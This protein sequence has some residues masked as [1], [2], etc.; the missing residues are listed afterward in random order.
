MKIG[1]EYGEFVIKLNDFRSIY[2]FFFWS[3]K[4]LDGQNIFVI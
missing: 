1:Y 3:N 4:P 2:S